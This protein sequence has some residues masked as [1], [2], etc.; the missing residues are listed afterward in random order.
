MSI[1]GG[2]LR[3]AAGENASEILQ[4]SLGIEIQ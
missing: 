1:A 2:A 3:G 4:S